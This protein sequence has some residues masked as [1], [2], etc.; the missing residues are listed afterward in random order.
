MA[1]EDS[2]GLR[3]KATAQKVATLEMCRTHLGSGQRDQE[4]CVMFFVPGVIQPGGH[5]NYQK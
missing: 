5:F 4:T 1:Q 2:L 3:A